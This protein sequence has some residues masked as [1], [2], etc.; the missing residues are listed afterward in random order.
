MI[1][2]HV[3]YKLA[4]K[5]RF[6]EAREAKSALTLKSAATKVGVQPTYLSR[7]LNDESS[8]LSEDHLYSMARLLKMEPAETDY[9]LL[10]RQYATTQNRHRRERLFAR[11]ETER[12]GPLAK[13]DQQ[14][15]DAQTLLQET[16]Y[17]FNPFCVLVHVALWSDDIRKNPRGLCSSLGIS[18]DALKE[19][20]KTLHA[21]EYIVVDDEDTFKVREVKDRRPH[22]GREHPLMRT[23]QATLKTALNS[24]LAQTSEEDKTSFLATF[25]LA[26]EHIEKVRARFK[27]FLGDVEKISTEPTR[28]REH[29]YQM[30]FD[31]LKWL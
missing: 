3:D 16:Q 17:L 23:H 19:I 15:W 27:E 1:Y 28:N 18:T 2:E 11:I 26:D 20:L 13:V 30:S 31:L 10:L 4:L 9:L 12:Q 29:L 6:K 14:K 8:H 22:F 7:C 24:R 5:A 21:R 25:T